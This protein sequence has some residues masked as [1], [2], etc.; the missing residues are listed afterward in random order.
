MTVARRGR[1][2]AVAGR[3]ANEVVAGAPWKSFA[4]LTLITPA[5][6]QSYVPLAH[7]GMFLSVIFTVSVRSGARLRLR[8]VIRLA[9]VTDCPGIGRFD[10]GG[11]GHVVLGCRAARSRNRKRDVRR[12][13]RLRVRLV[14]DAQVD[15]RRAAGGTGGADGSG[16]GFSPF[17]FGVG[18]SC[19]A[20]QM[21]PVYGFVGV[22]GT[23]EAAGIRI[24]ASA[25]RP[26]IAQRPR[27]A[28]ASDGQDDYV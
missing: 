28:C 21:F 8:S 16:H 4:C 18:G 13:E 26:V 1:R 24:T 17:G 3:G 20:S 5:A 19:D 11:V 15:D 9:V 10:H 7:A 27:D 22:G 2:Q 23:A 6:P 14:V 25:A 12:P